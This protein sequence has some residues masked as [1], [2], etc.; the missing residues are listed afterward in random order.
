MARNYVKRF[1]EKDQ[2]R[3][4]KRF[5]P[6]KREGSQNSLYYMG[7]KINFQLEDIS[8]SGVAV[9]VKDASYC[10]IDNSLVKLQLRNEGKKP[11]VLYARIVY[12]FK[13]EK[14]NNPNRKQEIWNGITFSM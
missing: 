1:M 13:R 4:Y 5:I 6:Q 11:C 9:L 8:M 3:K 12:S 10:M 2:R 7:E 14:A